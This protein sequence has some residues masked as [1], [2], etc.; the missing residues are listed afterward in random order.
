MEQV[1]HVFFPVYVPRGDRLREKTNGNLI[2]GCYQVNKIFKSFKWSHA[3]S[4]QLRLPIGNF[5]NTQPGKFNCF[6][7]ICVNFER[8]NLFGLDFSM[9]IIRK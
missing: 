1:K 9:N 7:N 4:R 2:Q 8:K 3:Y 5:Q 6:S